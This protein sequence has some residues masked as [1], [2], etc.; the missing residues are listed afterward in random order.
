MK[1]KKSLQ[2]V[3][4]HTT[5]WSRVSYTIYNFLPNDK[6]LDQSNLKDFA[7]DKINGTYKFN[8]LKGRVENIVGKG[9]NA[10]PTIFSKVLFVRVVA[11]PHS[12]AGLENRRSLV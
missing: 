11:E 2:P 8:F 9:E 1:G 7:D 3:T 5:F 10:F 12:S 6:I 4:V